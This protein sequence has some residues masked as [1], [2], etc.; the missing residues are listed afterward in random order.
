MPAQFLPDDCLDL[1]V[2]EFTAFDHQQSEAIYEWVPSH[3]GPEV[4]FQDLNSR[5]WPDSVA[6]PAGGRSIRHSSEVSLR[7]LRL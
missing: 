1:G 5:G 3:Q 2:S 4:S 7:A 6:K